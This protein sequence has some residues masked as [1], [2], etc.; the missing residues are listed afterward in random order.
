MEKL[1]HRINNYESAISPN[2]FDNIM[3]ERNKKKQDSSIGFWML[4]LG[5]FALLAFANL[6][7]SKNT[8]PIFTNTINTPV[9]PHTN[10][11]KIKLNTHA[12]SPIIEQKMEEKSLTTKTSS[13]SLNKKHD[14]KA[15][16][17]KNHLNLSSNIDKINIK[18]TPHNLSKN[19]ASVKLTPNFEIPKTTSTLSI[20]LPTLLP[21]AL[22]SSQP[23]PQ[24]TL[25]NNDCY[26]F[27]GRSRNGNS[28]IF[29]DLWGSPD[30]VKSNLTAKTPEY[31]TYPKNRTESEN[32]EFS[33]SAQFGIGLETGLGVVIRSGVNYSQYESR[34]HTSNPDYKKVTIEQIFDNM[35]N[36]IRI[37]TITTI[38]SLDVQHY[39]T[40]KYIGVPLTLGYTT[41]GRKLDI[42]IN[43]GAQFNINTIS[44]GR[45]LG[46]DLQ[47]TDFTLFQN[48]DKSAYK[49]K[50]GVQGIANL[51]FAYELG[52]H[53]DLILAPHVKLTPHSI[54]VKDYPITEKLMT[55]GLWIGTRIRF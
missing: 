37:D 39:N 43:V 9:T 28:N 24:Y 36:P 52:N 3:A 47:T 1:R 10:T 45:F 6:Q 16:V 54:A 31:K 13:I 5:T 27:S 51:T 22:L 50:I 44:K 46:T 33:Y 7:L 11:P 21:K 30:Y 18:K 48:S 2:L 23:T 14:N 53:F 20:P 17:P 55:T 8:I 12:V 34:F 42:G 25:P 49:T 38:G 19:V 15:I 26:A 40:H 32:Y 35:G 4:A 29:I 41:S